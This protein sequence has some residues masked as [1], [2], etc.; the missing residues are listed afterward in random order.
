M[1]SILL[2]GP[3]QL[4]RDGAPVAL[5]R[6]RARALVYYLA[7]QAA[8]VRREQL[9]TLLWQDNERSASQQQL[10]STL[11]SVRRALGPALVGDDPLFIAPD[12]DVDQR[13]L[14]ALVAAPQVGEAELAA[15]LARYRDDFLA[16]FELPDAELFAEWLAAERER[17]RLLATRGLA[18]LARLREQRADYAGALDALRRALGF[19]PLQEDV[20]RDAIRLHYLAGDRVGAIRRYA[21]L[22]ELLDAEL[23]V[24]PMRETQALYD[25]VVTDSLQ[26]GGRW[27]VDGGGAAQDGGRLV[28]P[29]STQRGLGLP[30]TVLRPPSTALPFTGRDAELAR[31][32]VAT[33]AGRLALIEGE[34]GIGKTRLAEEFVARHGGLV[35]LGAA[36]ELEQSIPY[37][38][39]V[40]ALRALVARPDWPA[41]RERLGLE[42]L[43]LAEAARLLPELAHAKQ[44]AAPPPARP[45][46]ARLWEG[47]ARLMLALARLAPVALVL[48]DLHW[49]DASTL[50]LLGYLLRRIEGEPLRILATARPTAPSTPL[51]ALVTALTREG[52]LERVA[53]RRLTPSETE[54]LARSLSPAAAR[55]LATW[56]QRSAEGNPYIIDE[57][58]R[59]ARAEGI[60]APDGAVD[61]HALSATPVVPQTVY[62]LIEAR[63]ARLSDAARRVLDAAVAAGREFEFELVARA[64]GLSEGAALD[65]LDE[66]R[67]AR[68]LEQLPDG[69]LRFD[70]TLT[71]EVA[72]R[73][74]GEPRHR[75]LHRRLAEALEALHRDRLDD[76]AGLIA[77]H[78]AEGGAP[79]RA[80][81]FAMRAGRRAASVAAWSE[82]VAFYEQGLAGATPEQRP[83][84]L[85]ALGNALFLGGEAARATERYREALRLANGPAEVRTLRLNLA[86]A[87][88]PQGRFAE[89]I[90]LVRNLE[91]STPDERWT[92]LFIWGTA[93]SIEGADLAEASLRLREAERIIVEQ[94]APDQT[95]LAQVRFELGSVAAQ[96]GDLPRAVAYYHE[97]LSVADCAGQSATEL[98][99]A[100]TWRILARNNLAYHL[101]LLGD[102]PSAA[103]YAAEGARLAEQWG[104]IGLQ[105]YLH[106]T[107]GEIALA[108]DD[109]DGAEA[110]FSAGLAL[111]ERL[112]L[113]ERVAGLT[114]NLG[115]LALRR[116]QTGVAVQR[117]STALSQADALGT[118]HLAAQVRL[119]LAP[120]L[121]PAEA[122]AALAEARAIAESGSR[123]RLLAEL[124]QVEA[125]L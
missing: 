36:R 48:D 15:A 115:L 106:S 66:L 47:V 37:Q 116:G 61:A 96:Q 63:L 81:S 110:Q 3:P 22:R 24:P 79:E 6:R 94:A 4:L 50:G 82:A 123:R 53:L 99:S 75:A 93:L 98:E 108:L 114:A 56:L 62:S 35:L 76:V 125:R 14:A 121:P 104:A 16:G 100:L 101:L 64:A 87:L 41:L 44:A 40:A 42:P 31:L 77:S 12:V 10:R 85:M 84:A 60:L 25:A 83:A 68:L 43:W 59:L 69:R 88:I 71:M 52:R 13:A 80:A 46:E 21:Q 89:V 7:A 58:V 11:H 109:L 95:A 117:L 19:D 120:L 18:R 92:A 111:A 27:T 26:D 23:G 20:Q 32:E 39:L 54:A 90:D 65:A 38:P 74:V 86:R 2:L 72:Y 97:A 17:T 45:D 107:S 124:A 105:P 70:H 29:E 73:E 8:P 5:P 57:L 51:G 119:W 30:S 28:A 118:R 78:F 103:R 1:L 67:A 55:E 113:P 34:A 102:L 122:H 33:A 49:A 112:A 91:P 9:L